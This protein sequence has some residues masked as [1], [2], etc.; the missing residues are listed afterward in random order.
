MSWIKDNK[1]LVI[2]C[3][4][5]LA[6]VVLL[7]V[8]GFKG[9]TRYDEGKTDYEAASGEVKSYARMPLYPKAEHRDGKQKALED[10]RKSLDSLQAE[11]AP[12]RPKELV[13]VSPQDFTNQLKK[14]NDEVGKAFKDAGT[15]VPE[16][17]F[18]GF[19]NY[20]TNL[21]PSEATGILN[22][23]LQEIRT[24]MLALAKAKASQLTNLY[25]PPLTEEASGEYKPQDTDIARALPL[26]ISFV[27]PEKSV[28]EFLSTI[29][30]LENQYVVIRSIRL[31]ST[32]KD[33]PKAT[34]AKFDHPAGPSPAKSLF[35]SD[36]SPDEGDGPLFVLP[37]EEPK[38][39]PPGGK[40]APAA[41]TKPAPV[42]AT[43]P[44][45]A[46]KP[47]ASG[48]ILAQVLGN[49]EVQVFLRLDLLQFLPAKQLP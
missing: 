14:V 23:Q 4:T 19:E 18:C 17:F 7:G 35:P 1:F 49:E 31:C 47:A 26:E 22:Y 46:S 48:R 9:L 45:A 34:D 16:T 20:Q 36:F 43:K 37:S 32:K 42:A 28:R 44:A 33:P 10:Y 2:L 30:H 29:T 13:N 39:K 41:G 21:A 27:A 5:T 11:F 25:R 38:S 15:T 3:G 6:G 24:L 40:P 8:A 12:Y